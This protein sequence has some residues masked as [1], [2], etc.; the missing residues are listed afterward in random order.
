MGS[1]PISQVNEMVVDPRNPKVVYAAGPSGIF[2]SEDS[3]LTWQPSG[4]GLGTAAIVALALN[5]ARPD[6]MFAA[7]DKG[8]LYRTV[9]GAKNWQVITPAK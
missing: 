2:R 4:Q 6:R 1:L 9:D 3:G 7:S 8:T 5:P